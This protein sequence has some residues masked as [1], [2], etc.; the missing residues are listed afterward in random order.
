MSRAGLRCRP[1]R[2]APGAGDIAPPQEDPGLDLAGEPGERHAGRPKVALAGAERLERSVVVAA[3]E[4][5][6]REVRDR[7][8]EHGTADPHLARCLEPRLEL[9]TGLDEVVGFVA[10]DAEHDAGRPGDRSRPALPVGLLRED[11]AADHLGL[12][13]EAGQGK[14]LAEWT[15]RRQ[16]GHRVPC[17]KRC[18][19]PH[20]QGLNGRHVFPARER[21]KARGQEPE[22]A[23]QRIV[24]HQP[25]SL[26]RQVLR[27]GPGHRRHE[28]PEDEQPSLGR[29][30]R[31]GRGE[32]TLGEGHGGPHLARLEE[33]P[34]LQGGELR[35]RRDPLRGQGLEPAEQGRQLAGLERRPRRALDEADRAVDRAG[36]QR[37]VDRL[38]LEARPLEP[39][40]GALVELPSLV[41]AEL[42]A[43][44]VGEETVVA[45][46]APF[47]IERDEEQVGP[48][49]P[50]EQRVGIVAT[51]QLAAQLGP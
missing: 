17:L 33:R 42:R 35:A 41:L 16:D 22:G 21:C 23:E 9:A 31:V 49:R 13:A 47:G 27:V 2:P 7:P 39:V 3:G 48:L 40:C 4:A 51:G 6:E 8:A 34:C 10:D 44:V 32:M 18:L 5:N 29:P 15:D 50:L 28:R 43:E 25:E 26:D 45:V 12:A 37:M 30:A 24:A 20:P 38:R 1:V 14:G 19:V 46:P 11:G 36:G